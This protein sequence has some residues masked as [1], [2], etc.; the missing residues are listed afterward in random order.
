MQQANSCRRE[1]TVT[2]MFLAKTSNKTTLPCS[3]KTRHEDVPERN[4]SAVSF[5]NLAQVGSCLISHFIME[6]NTHD[7]CKCASAD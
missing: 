1:G 5:L 7:L 6:K 2:N 4:D 3:Y